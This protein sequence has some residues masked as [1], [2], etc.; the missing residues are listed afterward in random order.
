MKL[1]R[2][3]S[4]LASQTRKQNTQ[5]QLVEQRDKI[6]RL[7]QR[8]QEFNELDDERD[9]VGSEE[10]LL[11]EDESARTV[12]HDPLTDSIVEPQDPLDRRRGPSTDSISI[13]GAGGASA[14]LPQVT[15]TT[16]SSDL[17]STTG[18]T[19]PT[20]S[21]AILTHNRLEQE[22]LTN[23]LLSMAQALRES[24]QAFAS[25][26]ESE[27]GVLD[28]TAEGMEKNASGMKAAEKRMGT[29]RRMTEGKGW[30]GRMLIYAYIAGLMM[31]AMVIV[32]ALPK[33][34]FSSAL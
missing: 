2:Q 26:L 34:R 31:F 19:V 7:T 8:L 14:L 3:Q 17:F 30:F 22:N 6:K 11:A 20:T 4:T 12:P 28:R 9:D 24:S 16:S 5:A 23:S 18:A 1:E 25:S 13:H 29:L 32:G 21:E 33:L 10:D 15:T 27:K